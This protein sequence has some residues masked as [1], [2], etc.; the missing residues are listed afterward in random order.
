[1]T[2]RAQPSTLHPG[3]DLGLR[4]I[5]TAWRHPLVWLVLMLALFFYKEVFLGRSFSPADALFTTNPWQTVKP[6][7]FVA[8]SNDLRG[9]ETVIAYPHRVDISTDIKRYGL[10]LWQDHTLGGSANTFSL[11]SLGAFA[12]PPFLAF[13]VLPPEVANTILHVSIPLLAGAAM[14][15][16]LGRLVRHRTSRLL[17]SLAYAL[18]GYIIVW[19]SAFPL[20]AAVALLP[21]ALYCA[22][23]F[24]DERAWLLGAVFAAVLAAV[25]I[26]SYP[27]GSIIF[28]ALVGLFAVCWWAQ[29]ARQRT[30]PLL[31]L[32]LLGVLGLG[33][34][35]VALLPTIQELTNYASKSFRGPIVSGIPVR[36]LA[37]WVFP[38]IAGN[39]IAHDWRAIGN[40]CEYVAYD[41]SLPLILALGGGGLLLYR[42]FRASPLV[43][44]ALVATALSLVLAYVGPVIRVVNAHPPLNNLNPPRWDFGVEFGVA[45]LAAYG[46]DELLSRENRR[47]AIWFAA[48]ATAAVV[49]AAAVLVAIK[50]QEF[51]HGNDF[52]SWDYRVRLAVLLADILVLAWV[53]RGPRREIAAIATV[54]VVFI[55]LFT[56][57][58]NF[59]PAIPASEMYPKTPAL[60]YLQANSSGYRVL[61]AG[62]HYLEDDFNVYGIDVIT[63]YDH[64]RDDRY[65]A[66][67]GANMSAAEQADWRSTGHLT[68]GDSLHLDDEVFNVLGVRYAYFPSVQAAAPARA[69][70][71]WRQVYSGPD[72]LVFENMAVLPRQ[73]LLTDGHSAPVP[74]AH[75]PLRPDEDRLRVTGAGQLVWAKAYDRDWRISVNGQPVEAQP[76]NGYFLSVHLAAST[77]D[78][79]LSYRP[80][81]YYLG[82]A[83]SGASLLLL[84]A[85]LLVP[86]ARRRRDRPPAEGHDPG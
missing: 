1:M 32:A 60:Q 55:D 63:G 65:V 43:N 66:L 73:F 83:V 40:Y 49:A 36:F 45:V 20:S 75:Q 9:D 26:F 82:A 58:V 80:R 46:L 77:T 38:N 17:G 13:L 85:L 12:Y 62:G 14:Y 39:P 59:N 68:L 64:F 50:H 53:V 30:L 33:L 7:S 25:I 69:A 35:M 15:M 34:S 51:L 76:Y 3:L 27:P 28:V 19:L 8:P 24:L 61:P 29:S 44:A 16:L 41:G 4:R 21:L 18:N 23:R 67:L 31:R 54:A 56:F 78:V 37:N 74:V 84:C 52:I 47:A 70:S 71:H 86:R 5:R 42:R 2:N 81:A 57:G 11:H 79:S 22:W 10:P 48:L 6:P 72:G